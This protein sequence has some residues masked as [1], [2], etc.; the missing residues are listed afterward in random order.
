MTKSIILFCFSF[1]FFSC[2]QNA[3]VSQ[4]KPPLQDSGVQAAGK[5]K[6]RMEKVSEI[7][8]K[9]EEDYIGTIQ[10]IRVDGVTP[11]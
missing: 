11:F 5:Q 8:L 2:N 3:K 1:L 6:I 9:E 4:D 7:R 10:R